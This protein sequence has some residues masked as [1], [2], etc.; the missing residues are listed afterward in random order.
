M[1]WAAYLAA[2]SQKPEDNKSQVFLMGWSPSTG[3][4][5]WVLRPLFHTKEWVPAGNNRS[6]Y[7]NA[8]VDKY[9]DIGMTENDPEKR[10]EAYLKAQELIIKDAGWITMFVLDNVNGRRK[11]I[12]GLVESPLELIFL[13]D[14]VKE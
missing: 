5:D 8:E 10:R 12:R 6:F 3:D 1:D 7:S 11:N 14:V 9:V 2:T 4:S 13:K